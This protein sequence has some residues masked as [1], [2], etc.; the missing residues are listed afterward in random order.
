M[1]KK[2]LIKSVFALFFCILCGSSIFFWIYIKDAS[3]EVRTKFDGRRWSLP[4]IIYARPLEIYPGMNLSPNLLEKELELAGYRKQT[5]AEG[6]GSFSRDANSFSI[7]TRDFVFPSGKE[8]SLSLKIVFADHKIRSLTS[9]NNENLQYVRFDPARIGSFHPLVHEDRIVLQYNEIPQQLI[10]GLLATEDR[11]FLEHHGV[12]IAGILRALWVNIKA[13]KTVQGG[14]TLTQQ[15]VKNYFLDSK[16]T[17]QRKFREAVMASVLEYHY[18]KQDIITAYINEVF[19]GQDGTRAVHGFGLASQFY[20]RRDLKELN[21]A[22]L[23]A[24]IGMVKGPSYYD[25]RHHPKR[26]LSRRNVVLRLMTQQHFLTQ[27]EFEKFSKTSLTDVTPQKNGFNRFPA[28][29]DLVRRQII[30]EYQEQDLHHS[31]LKILTTLDPQI[32]WQAE[33]SLKNVTS[34]LNSSNDSTELQGAVIVSTRVNGEVKAVVGSTKDKHGFNRALDAKRTIG[35]LIKPVVYLTALENGYTLASPI[36]DTA[37]KISHDNSIWAPQN[38]DR[39]EHGITPLYKALANSYN[40]ATVRLGLDIGLDQVIDSLT[41]LGHPHHVAKY[42]SLFLGGIEMTPLEVTQLYQTIGAGGFYQPLQT[43][44][45]VLDSSNQLLSRYPLN[46]DS[47][48]KSEDIY[49]LTHALNRVI[50]EGT[51]QKYPFAHK[52]A[53]A[54]KTGTSNDFR[55]SWF[56]G[57]SSEHVATVWLGRDDNKPIQFTGSTG[58]LRVWGHL[59]E[60]I[61]DNSAV[62]VEPAGITWQ[63][64][65]PVTLKPTSFFET[66]YVLLPFRSSNT[67]TEQSD[68]AKTGRL[69]T[70]VRGGIKNFLHTLD[71]INQ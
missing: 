43:I 28:F 15:L 36:E 45:G 57:F 70:G 52:E 37:I 9:L 53:F 50:Q 54:G 62:A 1:T 20:F 55:D 47:R 66:D 51:A 12:S 10:E 48:F 64:I 33:T 67:I 65:S 58:A 22:Q 30:N 6:A 60:R 29:V 56:A 49:L 38:Y 40:L 68:N 4:A 31:G 59:L 18:S 46:I 13:G 34:S 3:Q 32:Q 16:R 23:A 39:I 41:R 69:G 44:Q 14:S 11:H 27:A 8:D 71:T 25:L 17:L 26:C 63:K 35:S 7:V 19:L 24:L 61:S 42:P 21:S 5:T 2:W